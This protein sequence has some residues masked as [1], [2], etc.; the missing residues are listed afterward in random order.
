LKPGKICQNQ[1]E[2]SH[3]VRNSNATVRVSGNFSGQ[4]ST[5][6]GGQ[7]TIGTHTYRLNKKLEHPEILGF[8]LLAGKKI[9]QIFLRFS[10]SSQFH[11]CKLPSGGNIQ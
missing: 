8:D 7:F 1:F 6:F 3:F 11:K 2:H 9:L 10:V 5:V 4:N